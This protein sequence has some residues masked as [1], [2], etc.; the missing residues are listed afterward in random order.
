LIYEFPFFHVVVLDSTL[1]TKIYVE[2]TE[3]GI[4]QVVVADDD[5]DQAE[6]PDEEDSKIAEYKEICRLERLGFGHE[7]E[8]D[9]QWIAGCQAF[10]AGRAGSVV[11]QLAGI[12][13]QSFLHQQ[14]FPRRTGRA[15][16]KRLPRC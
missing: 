2:S 8:I 14:K 10:S 1:K 11:V 4:R 6:D 9:P 5:A 3:E 15:S 13:G 12:V 16:P 7:V